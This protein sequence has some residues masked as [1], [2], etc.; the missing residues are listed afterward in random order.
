MDPSLLPESA[1]LPD[2]KGH[3]LKHT[4]IAFI[5]VE[6][7][8]VGLRYFSRYLISS[9]SGAD[10]WLMPLAWLFSVGLCV[11]SLGKTIPRTP[12]CRTKWEGEIEVNSLLIR[13]Q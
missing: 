9:R 3:Q 1:F 4:A 10:D 8:F 13:E 5:V 11:I 12:F 2:D 7:L 6:T